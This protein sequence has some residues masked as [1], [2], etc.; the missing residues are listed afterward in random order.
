L[1]NNGRAPSGNQPAH[2]LNDNTVATPSTQHAAAHT[3]LAL[4]CD[5]LSAFFTGARGQLQQRFRRTERGHHQQEK[6]GNRRCRSERHPRKGEGQRHK[7]QSGSARWIQPLGKHNGK[8]RNPASRE[9]AVS[10][11]IVR[12]ATCLRLMSGL[13]KAA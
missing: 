5:Q 13:A 9:I 2:E 1:A 3:P 11:T 12:M 10:A 8:Y 6:E 4:A 7:K